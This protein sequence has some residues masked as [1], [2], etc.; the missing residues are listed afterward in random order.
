[1]QKIAKTICLRLWWHF[2]CSDAKWCKVW[3]TI[4]TFSYFVDLRVLLLSQMLTKTI[5]ASL[6]L[7]ISTISVSKH[8]EFRNLF[9]FCQRYC[10]NEWFIFVYIIIMCF[11]SCD[12][13]CCTHQ[14][15]TFCF[16]FCL[17]FQVSAR[18]GKKPILEN[19]FLE[20]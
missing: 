18:F 5:H 3:W 20:F 12:V 13:Y 15:E 2:L 14:I 16:P 1:M 11:L 7:W 19:C 10:G 9:F 8:N 4:F 6:L 17:C